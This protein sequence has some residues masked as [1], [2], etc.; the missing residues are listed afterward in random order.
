M[1]WKISFFNR[2]FAVSSFDLSTRDLRPGIT[3][4]LCVEIIGHIMD[5]IGRAH[6]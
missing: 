2:L 6:V 1:F 3:G 5:E 4:G